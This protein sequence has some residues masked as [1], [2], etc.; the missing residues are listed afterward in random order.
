MD[1]KGFIMVTNKKYELLTN[2]TIE[3][4]GNTLYRIRALRD[5]VDV[6][7]GDIGGYIQSE[8]NLSHEGNCWIY[9]N[10]VVY[11]A[12]SVV[13]NAIVS[14][15]A[16]IHGN[17]KVIGNCR[18]FGNAEVYEWEVIEWEGCVYGA[19]KIYG[20]AVV[21]GNVRVF[22]YSEI[23]GCAVIC[24][25]SVIN[26]Y[27]NISGHS[28]ICDNSTIYDHAIITDKVKLSGNSIISGNCRIE[29]TSTL[30]GLTYIFG[31][32]IVKNIRNDGTL[33]LGKFAN[34][35][36]TTDF[37]NIGPIG[38]RDDYTTFYKTKD[39]GIYVCCGCFN[40]SLEEFEEVVKKTH[41]DN[42]YAKEY[43]KAI[44]MVKMYFYY[45]K[46]IKYGGI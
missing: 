41:G 23:H 42:E 10:A 20:K 37:I 5:F 9:G 39:N 11:E 21:T 34:I 1:T 40:G 14:G 12:A 30:C 46:H 18:I 45:T 15:N 32:A 25:F 31:D 27:A 16:K 24:G 19:S 17:S 8:V 13:G 26:G 3:I 43:M 4:N 6:K 44:E 33:R 36:N 38:S 28:V 29:G 2:D 7:K 35:S 22:G